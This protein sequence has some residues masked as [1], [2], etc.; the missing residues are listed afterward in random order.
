[1]AS[2]DA[3]RGRPAGGRGPAISSPVTVR[4]VRPDDSPGLDALLS[5]LGEQA[6]HRRWF[7]GS[8]DIHRAAA[9][10]AHPDLNGAVG[11]VATAPDGQVVGHAAFIPI[12]DERAEVCFEVAAPW[13][14]HGRA[15]R[16]LDELRRRAG[17][18]GL[19]SLVAEV[20]SENADMLAVMREHGPSREHREGGVVELELPIAG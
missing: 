14:Q 20:L 2:T 18:R 8:V 10:A 11:L 19:R 5:A 17:E 13:R 12:D 9:W 16:L 4:P 3:P 1:M 15:G 6:R 7:T